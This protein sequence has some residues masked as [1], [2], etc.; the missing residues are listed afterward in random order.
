MTAPTSLDRAHHLILETFVTRGHA[1]SHAELAEGLGVP[2]AE[3][4][5]LLHE[6]VATGLPVWLQ[7][8]T[9]LIASCAPFNEVPTP[10]RVSVDGKPGWF[11]Q[12]GFEA[13]AMTWVL[14]GRTLRIDA[15]CPHCGEPLRLDVRDGILERGEPKAIV[16]YVDLP[17]REWARN[18]PDT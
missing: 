8:G 5:R 14:P 10:Y 13:L 3:G 17:F 16:C 15:P 1:P 6:L 7:P 9:D 4:R 11:A 2:P 18:W 12:C